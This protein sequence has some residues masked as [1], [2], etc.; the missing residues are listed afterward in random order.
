MN[1]KKEKL[2][3]SIIK[4]TVKPVIKKEKPKPLVTLTF[5][6]WFN[7]LK[8]PQHHKAGMRAF[9]DTKGKRTKEAWDRLFQGY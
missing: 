2:T 5:D 1:K 9:A 6:R 3:E 4:K 8:R 7:T